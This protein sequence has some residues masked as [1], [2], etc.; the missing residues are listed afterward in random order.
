MNGNSVIKVLSIIILFEMIF[1]S[2]EYVVVVFAPSSG[3]NYLRYD[4]WIF[5]ENN[6]YIYIPELMDMDANMP[7][8]NLSDYND[9]YDMEFCSL[10]RENHMGIGVLNITSSVWKT[11]ITAKKEDISLKNLDN[12]VY[13][14]Q[15]PDA[16]IMVYY[17]GNSTTIYL[18]LS[19]MTPHFEYRL[20][21]GPTKLHH[22]WNEVN[23]VYK[24]IERV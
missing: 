10:T 7:V 15:T 6:E 1:L 14:N 17:H 22:G 13:Q 2:L 23:V 5:S 4:I 21:C 18:K 12:I 3:H 9:V 11:H 19:Y 20:S 8:F 24:K 16:R